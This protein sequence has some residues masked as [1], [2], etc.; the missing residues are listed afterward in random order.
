MGHMSRTRTVSAFAIMLVVALFGA[1]CGGDDADPAATPAAASPA[2][3]NPGADDTTFA[4]QVATTDLA[5]DR[6][7]RVQVGV[8]SSRQ[9]A[10]VQLLSYGSVQLSFS[11]LGVDGGAPPEPGLTTTATYLPAPTTDDS[12]QAPTLTAPDV[13][14]GV[15]QA[16]GVRFEQAGVW[17]V[18]V[19]TQV[20]GIGPLSLD[21]SF[22]V[23]TEPSLPAPGQP[24]LATKN[25]TMSSKDVPPAAVDS[26]AQGGDPVPDPD[27]H[28]ST[29]AKAIAEGRPSLVLFATPVYCTSQFCGPTA[30][31]L[32][33][34]AKA[35]P[36][37]A[38]Y[39]H[40][41]IWKDFESSEANQAAL[42][43][44]FRDGDLTEPWLYLIDARGTIADRWGPLFDPEEVAAQLRALPS[45]KS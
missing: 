2:A 6:D 24:A 31:A 14:R 43:W 40:I 15:Y 20:E 37:K 36:D 17:S 9:D 11:F 34:L 16:T 12:G 21:A 44:L 33:E 4:A 28:R 3:A 38:E 26:R 10:G 8:F 7:E 18:T 39:I 29:I 1:S 22:V 5:I 25:L 42:D 45:M 30:D 27:Q 13:A 35:F 23:K 41:E 19:S 32:A